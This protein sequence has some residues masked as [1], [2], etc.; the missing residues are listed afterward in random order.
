MSTPTPKITPN[1]KHGSPFDRGGA[2]FYYHRPR[3]P[4]YYPEGTGHGKRVEIAEMTVEEIKEYH[5]G[6]TDG[7][8]Y[9]IQKEYDRDTLYDPDT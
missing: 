3:S 5:D 6:Y 7:E 8:K 4:H 9:N 1:R 2:D